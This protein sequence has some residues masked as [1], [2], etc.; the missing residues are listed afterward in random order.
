M[1]QEAFRNL[2][3]SHR[4]STLRSRGEHVSSLA[5]FGAEAWG[6]QLRSFETSMRI[7][8]LRG[9][10]DHVHIVAYMHLGIKELLIECET[11]MF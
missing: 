3:R 8:V 2:G 10:H 11:I 7:N 1:P 9:Y 4:A 5:M 6:N